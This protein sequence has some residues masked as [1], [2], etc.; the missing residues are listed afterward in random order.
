MEKGKFGQNV[1][2]GAFGQ[3]KAKEQ[4]EFVNDRFEVKGKLGLII[5]RVC[6]TSSVEAIKAFYKFKGGTMLFYEKI[7]IEGGDTSRVIV[8]GYLE[9]AALSLALSEILE[10]IKTLAGRKLDS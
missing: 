9:D 10:N 7:R 6:R 4:K 2:I 8:S 5:I 3:T 1:I